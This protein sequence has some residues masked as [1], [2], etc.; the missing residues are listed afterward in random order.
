MSMSLATYG[1]IPWVEAVRIV[2]E[3]ARADWLATTELAT[4]RPLP[5]E[6]PQTQC[7]HAWAADEAGPM[8]RLIPN[9]DRGLV[10]CTALVD[11]ASV[12][13]DPVKATVVETEQERYGGWCDHL[14]LGVSPILFRRPDPAS[15]TVKEQ[16]YAS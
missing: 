6:M 13:V 12:F 16:E 15:G 4:K 14:V 11:D 8:W 5:E 1:W 10:L 9:R 7:I 2:G 3:S